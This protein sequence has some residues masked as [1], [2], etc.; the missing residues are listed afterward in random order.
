MTAVKH[1]GASIAVPRSG[2]LPVALAVLCT[3]LFLTFL[4]NTVVSVGL[5]SVQAQLHAGVLAL[6][7]IV[8]AYALTFASAM[9][10]FGMIGDEFGRKKVMM[11]GA[12]VS[13]PVPSCAH[14][15]RTLGC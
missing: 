6:Q 3:L 9:L 12:A 13:A 4:D 7:W 8:G 10:A 11:A 15:R 14:W 1:R 2:G 5:G